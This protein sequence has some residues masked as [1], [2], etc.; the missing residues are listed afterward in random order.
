MT[1]LFILPGELWMF[2]FLRGVP[3]RCAAWRR[4]L[5]HFLFIPRRYGV[6]N[7]GK[8]EERVQRRCALGSY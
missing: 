6:W 3:S 2:S 1:M 5:R 8:V 7:R 4:D